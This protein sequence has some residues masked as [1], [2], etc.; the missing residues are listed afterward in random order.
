MVWRSALFFWEQASSA[1]SIPRIKMYIEWIPA[2]HNLSRQ[3]SAS[4]WILLYYDHCSKKESKDNQYYIFSLQCDLLL[5]SMWSRNCVRNEQIVS[6]FVRLPLI[7]VRWILR[8]RALTCSSIGN[9]EKWP[10]FRLMFL[11]NKIQ[12]CVFWV[13]RMVSKHLF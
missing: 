3:R 2:K 13:Y 7:A 1:L 12:L 10:I 4:N 5:F 8:L 6:D 11:Y 9:P